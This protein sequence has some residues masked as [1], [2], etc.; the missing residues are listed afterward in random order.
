M[1]TTY[2]ITALVLVFLAL[3]FL[4][5]AA[6]LS[7]RWDL[8]AMRKRISGATYRDAVS[9]ITRMVQTQSA[10]D[11]YTRLAARSAGEQMPHL[12]T[13]NLAP[14][15]GDI[16]PPPVVTIPQQEPPQVVE[17]TLPPVNV[18]PQQPM[19]VQPVPEPQAEPKPT[20]VQQEETPSG[21]EELP[22]SFLEAPQSVGN[23]EEHT[24]FLDESAHITPENPLERVL[25]IEELSSWT[26]N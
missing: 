22:T 11:T 21:Y 1:T 19:Q 23:E 12:T 17:P 5:T 6:F 24:N 4:F 14:M 15:T 20:P 8:K 25:L 16:T 10:T 18:A 3:T 13:G 9:D 2:M 7:I 26:T